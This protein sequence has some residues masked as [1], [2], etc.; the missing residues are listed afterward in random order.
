[1]DQSSLGSRRP[2][3]HPE[4]AL[5]LEAKPPTRINHGTKYVSK[6]FRNRVALL[7]RGGVQCRHRLPQNNGV[8]ELRAAVAAFVDFYSDRWLP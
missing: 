6:R 1:M 8:A 2:V 4:D 5:L 3:L 7:G